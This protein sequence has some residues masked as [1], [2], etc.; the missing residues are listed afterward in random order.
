MATRKIKWCLKEDD[1][2]VGDLL[3]VFDAGGSRLWL[4]T[5]DRLHHWF[6]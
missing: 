1:L 3:Y 6:V 5:H 4:V 2:K